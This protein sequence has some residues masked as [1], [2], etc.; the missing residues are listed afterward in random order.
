MFF[1]S[2]DMF[3]SKYMIKN[4]VIGGLVTWC[5]CRFFKVSFKKSPD[6]Y[7]SYGHSFVLMGSLLFGYYGGIYEGNNILLNNYC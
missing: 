1:K 2:I 3:Y 6:D 5:L 7:L 4:G